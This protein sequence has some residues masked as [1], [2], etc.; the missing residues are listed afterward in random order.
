MFW[1]H[2]REKQS[3]DKIGERTR[4]MGRDRSWSLG[5]DLVF[6]RVVVRMIECVAD[7]EMKETQSDIAHEICANPGNDSLERAQLVQDAAQSPEVDSFVVQRCLA[8]HQ[9]LGCHVGQSLKRKTSVD[10]P[11]RH[12]TED[13]LVT[14]AA[15]RG[16]PLF[17][18]ELSSHAKVSDLGNGEILVEEDCDPRRSVY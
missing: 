1:T 9:H 10:Q 7:G 17:L 8:F 12:D 4:V 13:G 3:I 18:L 5:T 16:R 6:E 2:I 11:T 14:H 15:E